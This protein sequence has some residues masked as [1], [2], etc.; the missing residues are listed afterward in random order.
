M[1]EIV[2][3][4]LNSAETAL[5][6]VA[7]RIELCSNQSLGGLTPNLEEFKY[8]KSEFKKPI[9]VMIRPKGGAFLYSESEFEQ[10]QSDLERFKCAG[11]DGFVFGILTVGNLIDEEKNKI[12]L[13]LAGDVP[14]TF[15][16]AFDRTPD[17]QLSIETLIRLGFKAVH[18]SGGHPFAMEGIEVLK[19]LVEKYSQ[20]IDI[21]VGGGVRSENISELKQYTKA[22]AFHSSAIPSYEIFTNEEEIKKIKKGIF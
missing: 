21:I 18:T 4:E 11:A 14:C 2:C 17:L 9:Y 19:S 7:D 1:L 5:K 6:S 8:L 3:F 22:V 13:S 16:R 20:Q 12:L 10:M 15:H